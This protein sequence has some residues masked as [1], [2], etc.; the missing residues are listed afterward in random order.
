MVLA[1]LYGLGKW[2]CAAIVSWKDSTESSPSELRALTAKK[3]NVYSRH[4]H[5]V[6]MFK[7][8]KTMGLELMICFW[9]P[10]FS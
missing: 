7:E 1:A 9:R 4:K 3:I 5:H 2:K 10:Q 8:L 6:R